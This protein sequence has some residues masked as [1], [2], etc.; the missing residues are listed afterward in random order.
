L[1]D[2]DT[3]CANEVEKS[4]KNY[5]YKVIACELIKRLKFG[6]PLNYSGPRGQPSLKSKS[7]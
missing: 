5:P 4:L 3:I 1:S 7:D 6:F 2:E